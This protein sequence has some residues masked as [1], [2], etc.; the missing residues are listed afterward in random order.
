MT[1]SKSTVQPR[2]DWIGGRL[3]CVQTSS[4]YQ[5]HSHRRRIT[6][7]LLHSS[8]NFRHCRKQA[9]NTVKMFRRSL[10]NIGLRVNRQQLEGIQSV[11]EGLNP[12]KY[13]DV[14]RRDSSTTTTTSVMG[15]NVKLKTM[16]D[17]SGP[18]FM[19]TLYWLF[20]KG[21]LQT[22]QQMQVSGMRRRNHRFSGD[23]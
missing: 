7:R 12:V 6:G 21:Y 9:A 17:L 2:G 13:G 18:S 16:D 3:G 15:D 19:Y 20:V 14:R 8:L 11:T 4:H 1:V 10:V 5:Q 23:D 22:A